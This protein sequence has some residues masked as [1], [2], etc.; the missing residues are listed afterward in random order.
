MNVTR[1]ALMGGIAAAGVLA[2]V[3]RIEAHAQEATPTAAADEAPGYGIVRIRAL[4]SAELNQALVPHVANTFLTATQAVPGYS[5]Y[6]YAFH[7]T[8]ETASITMTFMAD[9]AAADEADAVARDFVG[10]LD[11]RFATETPL[12]ERGPVRIYHPTSR[13]LSE[14]PPFL[15]NCAVSTRSWVSLPDAD[16]DDVVARVSD[17]LVPL[18]SE[19]PG[20]VLYVWMQTEE[21][22]LTVTVWETEEQLDAGHEAALAWVA[23]NTAD[24]STGVPVVNN[25]FIVYSDLAGLR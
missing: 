11:P 23:D 12:A 1:R 5:G 21:G 17:G 9:S 2:S 20:F 15:Y 10:G 24:T 16:L 6:L 8:D 3:P 22:R 25:G 14:L 18:L 19:M 4:A 7:D 13:P